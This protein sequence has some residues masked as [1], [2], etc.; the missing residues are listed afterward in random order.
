MLDDLDNINCMLDSSNNKIH[1]NSK[2]VI[3]VEIAQ[4]EETLESETKNNSYCSKTTYI[5]KEEHDKK[6]EKYSTCGFLCGVCI[7]FIWGLI[8]LKT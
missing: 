1:I 6:C 2:Y 3:D 7:I 5:D 8:N 4:K